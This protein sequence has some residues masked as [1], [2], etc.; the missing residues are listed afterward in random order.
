MKIIHL[1]DL[2]LP[3]KGIPWRDVIGDR[4][5]AKVNLMTRRRGAHSADIVSAAIKKAVE[6][7]PDH[8]VITGDFSNMAHEKEFE[9][10]KEVLK[11]IWDPQ[12]LSVVPGNH[13]YYVKEGGRLFTKYF[14]DLIWGP[15]V[16]K[17]YPGVKVLNND[18]LLLLF[19]SPMY[20]PGPISLG[21][22]DSDQILRARALISQSKASTI[23]A[24][25]HHNIHKRG[26]WVELTGRLINRK[27]LVKLFEE[28][29]INL[30]LTGHDHKHREYT[31]GKN[32]KVVGNGSSS[33]TPGFG[34]AV[35][36]EI[37]INGKDI[38]TKVYTF[39]KEKGTFD[40][41]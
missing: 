38:D 7:G 21:Y 16:P 4:F 9:F 13:D 30:V 18:V 17:V 8:I 32:I 10:A 15:T 36:T 14:G 35:F 33:L 31:I 1:S 40:A 12:K 22:I 29:H 34:R 37:T 6:L 19:K 26:P 5:T 24:A 41:S 20:I 2:H 25:F 28:L 11:P 23:I 27:E 39:N 3:V